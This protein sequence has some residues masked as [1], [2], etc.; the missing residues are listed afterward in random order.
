MPFVPDMVLFVV[1]LFLIETV[2]LLA[3]K[4]IIEFIS[5]HKIIISPIVFAE[6]KGVE[7]IQIFDSWIEARVP[8]NLP[9]S[10]W[11][12]EHTPFLLQEIK[13]RKFIIIKKI[14]HPMRKK[15][16]FA[17]FPL[18]HYRFFL[19][20]FFFIRRRFYYFDRIQYCCGIDRGFRLACIICMNLLISLWQWQR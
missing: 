5:V 1:H 13:S 6:N 7:I 10:L 3:D 15:T 16:I 4:F 11:C 20:F 2:D 14:C 18:T 17:F 12:D 8:Y 19:Y 9:T